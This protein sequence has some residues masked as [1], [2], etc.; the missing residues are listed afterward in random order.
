[1]GGKL[2]LLSEYSDFEIGYVGRF[3]L[4]LPKPPETF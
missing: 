2:G 4:W 1:M 3:N